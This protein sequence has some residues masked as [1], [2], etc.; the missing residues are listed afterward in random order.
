[1]NYSGIYE[2]GWVL[3]NVL[4]ALPPGDVN[5]IAHSHGGNVV[6]IAMYWANREIKHLINMATP[7]NWD[8]PRFS[9]GQ[10]AFSRCQ[11]SSWADYTQFGG[12][13]PEQVAGFVVSTTL[14]Y[15]A[16]QLSI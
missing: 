6:I 3:G 4:A 15:Q 1:V 5:V 8:L 16:S 11:L 10:G 12:S 2:G 14:A 9:M 7:V 13:S